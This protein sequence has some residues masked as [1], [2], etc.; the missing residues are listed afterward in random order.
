[1]RISRRDRQL[2]EAYKKATCLCLANGVKCRMNLDEVIYNILFKDNSLGIQKTNNVQVN[3][4]LEEW[5]T[6]KG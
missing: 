5:R 6:I 4:M 3:M 1:M 2:I